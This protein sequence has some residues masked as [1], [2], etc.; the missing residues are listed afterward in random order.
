MKRQLTPLPFYVA[1]MLLAGAL[2]LLV[3]LQDTL[4]LLP[5]SSSLLPFS[6]WAL[7]GLAGLAVLLD[8][9]VVPLAGGGGA[10]ASFAVYFAGLLVVGAGPTAVVAAV[11]GL[12][13]EGLV[14]RRAGLRVCF[15]AAHTVL[16]LL[17]A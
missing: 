17:G 15:N 3:A 8:L 6:L 9:M 12:V 5:V 10:S 2:A 14:R 4:Q 1:A 16:S 11:A 7:G 13:S